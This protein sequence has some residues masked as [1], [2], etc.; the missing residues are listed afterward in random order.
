MSGYS[1]DVVQTSSIRRSFVHS[2]A[3]VVWALAML[4]A[5]PE[6]NAR[7]FAIIVDDPGRVYS[8]ESNG[9]GTFGPLVL[10][11]EPPGFLVPKSK[12]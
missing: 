6:V 4:L 12:S 1:D 11:D 5:T 2:E 9:D 7:E 10:V 3:L 8:L